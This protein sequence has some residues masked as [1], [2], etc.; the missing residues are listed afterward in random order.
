MALSVGDRL[1]HYQIS[2]ALGAGGM[3]QVYRARDTR[4]NG[5]VA[6]K[7]VSD[8]FASDPDRLAR[9]TREAHTLAALNH[10]HIAHVYGIEESGDVHA[11]VMELIEGEDLAKRLARGKLRV[12]EALTIAQ[13]VAE[14]VE[15]AHDKGIVHRDLKPSN[16]MLDGDGR[17]RVLDFGL[18]T[19]PESSFSN[20]SSMAATITSPAKLTG[21]GVIVGTPAYMSPEQ[22]T[23][24]AADKRCDVWAFGCVL[25]EMITGKRTFDGLDTHDA[26]MAVASQEPD[27]SALGPEV[28]ES[29]RKLLKRCLEKNRKRRLSDMSAVRLELE[30]ALQSPVSGTQFLQ[31][32]APSP[33]RIPTSM[34]WA[35]AA[36]AVVSAI[37]V[38]VWRGRDEEVRPLT[39]VTADV[40]APVSLATSQG[41]SVVLS[42]DGRRLVF[43]AQPRIANQT[44]R[45]YTRTLDELAANVLPG[46]EGA[47]NPF[48]SP[49][50]QWVGFFA[51]GKLKKISI[52]GG[53]TIELADAPN[54]RGGS[55]GDDD[56]IVFMP[57]FYQGIW[58]IPAAG[59]E[60]VRLTTPI[61][62]T[63]THRWPQVLPGSKAFI[64][65][66][67]PAVTA[68]RERRDRLAAAALR[69][70][71]S[72]SAWCN[73]CSVQSPA[74]ISSSCETGPCLRRRSTWANSNERRNR[75][76]SS[77]TS[78]MGR[79]GRAA[80]SSP[81]PIPVPPSTC[82]AATLP[83]S[84]RSS[85]DWA[86]WQR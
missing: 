69:I 82:P 71:A 39:Q 15:A 29:V 26:M 86:R 25:Y 80:R 70:A 55:W 72:D 33:R 77:M 79:F 41:A 36:L 81:L 59:G 24:Q 16:I 34:A 74:G 50:G 63:G 30:E 58:R 21:R 57:D 73:A 48:F 4:L 44:S 46:T 68:Y 3:G 42:P 13:Q 37:A 22:V 18:A 54:G 35:V 1:G 20:E 75:Y 28:P 19:A 7:I 2:S 12:R 8:G 56:H 11:L 51:A 85:M 64:Y 43:A 9:F 52:A 76:Q 62:R 31:G 38:W 84:S 40:G 67:N 53:A 27:W 45:L 65:T 17:V 14:A 23:G 61:N 83:M 78:R 47:M 6:I 32:V 60:A 49:D 5:D 66:S 10:P